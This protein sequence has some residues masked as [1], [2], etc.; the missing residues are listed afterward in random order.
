LRRHYLLGFVLLLAIGT[1]LLAHSAS[2]ADSKSKKLTITKDAEPARDVENIDGSTI[3]VEMANANGNLREYTARRIGIDT[4]QT[5]HAYGK[6]A[7]SKTDSVLV[8]AEDDT[9]WLESDASDKGPYGHLPRYVWCKSTIDNR[10]HVLDADLVREGYALA[11][12]YQPNTTRQDALDGAE[13][14]AIRDGRGP[15][16][17]SDA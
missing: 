4:P 10:V 13:E 17:T 5:S 7:T 6:E 12:S 16:P 3:V 14:A 8:T 11:K 2:A 15:W 9:V 1:V